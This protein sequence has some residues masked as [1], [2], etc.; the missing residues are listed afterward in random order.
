MNFPQ[1][2]NKSHWEGKIPENKGATSCPEQHIVRKQ[3]AQGWDRITPHQSSDGKS[4]EVLPPLYPER[5]TKEASQGPLLT[6]PPKLND[7]QALKQ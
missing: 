6:A 2:K 5:P 7:L 4:K 3:D 1:K